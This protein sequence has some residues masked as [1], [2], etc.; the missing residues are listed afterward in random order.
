MSVRHQN[1]YRVGSK[2]HEIFTVI[3]KKQIVT[4]SM[5][6]ELSFSS[7]DITVILSPRKESTRGDLRGNISAKG[8]FYYMETLGKKK[9]EEKRFRLRWRA[10]VL[11]PRKR[12]S[13]EV[14]AKAEKVTAKAKSTSKKKTA[15]SAKT[16]VAVKVAAVT[17]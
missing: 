2:Y 17:A 10:E 8:E 12:Q 9:G 11:E 16:A 15:N 5:L 13:L 3:Q 1:P 14:T 4:R 6:K 7:F